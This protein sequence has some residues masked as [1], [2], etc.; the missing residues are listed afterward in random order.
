MLPMNRMN[1]MIVTPAPFQRVSHSIANPRQLLAA[2]STGPSGSGRSAFRRRA[3]VARLGARGSRQMFCSNGDV[4]G[5]HLDEVVDDVVDL[6]VVERA[7]EPDAPRRHRVRAPPRSP[8][9]VVDRDDRRMRRS[10]IGPAQI[11]REVRR[12][13]VA[14]ARRGSRRRA[15]PARGSATQPTPSWF[16]S[17]NGCTAQL[18]ALDRE[19]LR[20]LPP[21]RGCRSARA[22]SRAG[23]TPRRRRRARRPSPG[24]S[25]A[26]AS[27]APRR[28]APGRM[29]AG[30]RAAA[31]AG[32][33]R[34]GERG[35]GGH[36]D[37]RRR[38]RAGRR[39]RC[40]SA[41][42]IAVIARPSLSRSPRRRGPAAARDRVGAAR[43]S[44]DHHRGVDDDVAVGDRRP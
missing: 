14:V 4:L 27:R 18:A 1:P 24:A 41:A 3:L 15:A 10:L 8:G 2:P 16:S 26:A 34:E 11:V 29:P 40:S 28:T 33:L 31:P 22:A 12:V 7:L 43:R 13:G 5:A 30:C 23:S 25:A 37:R 21:A 36:D 44:E 6:L 17:L 19:R 9:D 38:A 32:R 42:S 35:R 39:P 20:A